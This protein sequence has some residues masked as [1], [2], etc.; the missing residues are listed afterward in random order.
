MKLIGKVKNVET[1][2]F[3]CLCDM[4]AIRRLACQQHSSSLYFIFMRPLSFLFPFAHAPTPTLFPSQVVF[5]IHAATVFPGPLR[6]RAH[7][8]LALPLSSFS[9]YCFFF[10]SFS[11][12]RFSSVAFSL[13]LVFLLPFSLSLLSLFLAF[14]SVALS[15]FCCYL[16]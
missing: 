15:P 14:S 1:C 5:H 16:Y 11:L 13:F 4:L 6:S 10:F 7:S 8:Y 2:S 3:T 12:S 9:S